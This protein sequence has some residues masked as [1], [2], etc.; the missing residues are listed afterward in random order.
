MVQTVRE[1]NRP[2]VHVATE[3]EEYEEEKHPISPSRLV[4]ALALVVGYVI[5]TMFLGYLISTAIFL[6]VFIWIGG[7]RR[8][9]VPLV[10][11]VGALVFTYVF[12]GVVYVSLPSGVGIFDAITVAIYG[13]LGIQ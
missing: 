6:G 12:I 8:W 7:Q 1:R 4:L 13:L 10:A 9:Y 3:F 2:I 11:V 5:A